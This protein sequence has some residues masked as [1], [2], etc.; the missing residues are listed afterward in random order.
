MANIPRKEAMLNALN[1]IIGTSKK[2]N[3]INCHYLNSLKAPHPCRFASSPLL[4]KER[5]KRGKVYPE[6]LIKS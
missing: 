4:G 6:Y 5:G 1:L 3:S 2:N